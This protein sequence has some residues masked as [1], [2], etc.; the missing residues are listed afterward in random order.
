MGANVIKVEPPSGDNFRNLMGGS[1]FTPFN[2]GKQSVCVDMKTDDG[3][4]VVTELFDEAD[5]VVESFRPGVLEKYDLDYESVRTRNEDVI[6]CSLSGFGR[7][8]PYSSYPGYDPCVQA[9]SGLMA[10]TGYLDRPPVRIRASLID[11]G[12]GANAAYAILAAVRQRDRGGT[13]TAIDISLFDVA[14]SWMSYWVSRY[15]R[16]GKLPERAGGQ[17]IGSAPNGVFST[18][19]GYVYLATLSEAMYERLCRFLGREDLLED[20]RFETIDDRLEHRE[21]LKEEFTGEFESYDA[22]ELEKGLMDAG[23]PTGAVRTVSDI[24]DRDPHVAERSMLV[25]SYNPEADDE[26]VAPAL[27]FR[28][29]SAIHD[30]TFSTRPPKKGEHTTDILEALSYPEEEIADLFDQ[31]VV[32]SEG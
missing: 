4:A 30:G 8:G 23:V 28:F 24:V 13:G 20:E 17:G 7:T 12:T 26:V 29:S 6:Y 18:G 27:P 16:T 1:M 19:D 21:L 2:H 11:C 15:D 5:I 14:V 9:V 22:I 10:I 3:H 25:D 32:F 31:N